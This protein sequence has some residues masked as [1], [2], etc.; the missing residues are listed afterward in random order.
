MILDK[1]YYEFFALSVLKEYDPQRFQKI[2]HG[3]SPDL[4]VRKEI[5]I[6]VTQLGTEQEFCFLNIMNRI[7]NGKKISEA[8]KIALANC[9]YEMRDQML[10]CISPQDEENVYRTINSKI[11]KLNKGNY[12]G[13]KKHALFMFMSETLESVSVNDIINIFR[14]NKSENIHYDE[15]FVLNSTDLFIYDVNINRVELKDICGEMKKHRNF[16]I[17]KQKDYLDRKERK[18]M[19][20]YIADCHFGHCNMNTK[21]DKR[22]FNS[23]EEM[24]EY[25]IKQWNSVVR[26]NDEVVILGDFSYYDGTTTNKILRRLNGKKC[27][28]EGNHDYR[29]LKDKNFDQNLIH[30]VK[31]YAELNDDN[32]KVICS[33]YPIMFYNGQYRK[34]EDGSPKSYMLY[35]HVHISQDFT[36]MQQMLKTAENF[37]YFCEHT[38]ENTSVPFNMINCFCVFSNYIPL[39]LDEW[40]E[41]ANQNYR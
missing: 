13:Y 35:G 19:R 41:K 2:K 1:I 29:F 14:K 38:E 40:I 16:A 24:D 30:W 6:E 8:D 7:E 23:V 33:H 9:G 21:M 15:I 26:K 17:N 27:L 32:R 36:L 31:P 34:M 22:G 20:R 18:R 4:H 39:T 10:F 11:S 37:Q 25:M 12:N 28:V 3:D 5:G